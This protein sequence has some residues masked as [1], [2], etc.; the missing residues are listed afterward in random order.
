VHYR[1]KLT[2]TTLR[3]TQARPVGS[4]CIP[5]E[6]KIRVLQTSRQVFAIKTAEIN[7]RPRRTTAG[8]NGASGGE[9]AEATRGVERLIA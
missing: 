7:D 6:V 3:A 8:G 1:E 5:A 9:E 4:F 2:R